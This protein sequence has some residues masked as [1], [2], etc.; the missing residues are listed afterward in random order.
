MKND[1]VFVKFGADGFMPLPS[2]IAEGFPL[3]CIPSMTLMAEGGT[4]LYYIG[5]FEGYGA[6]L[7]HGATV[8]HQTETSLSIGRS[9]FFFRWRQ[10]LREFNVDFEDFYPRRNR[11]NSP[12]LNAVGS[13]IP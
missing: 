13:Q 5:R 2:E 8:H 9:V 3:S 4:N 7:N 11:N 10:L 12:R 1:L 6:R